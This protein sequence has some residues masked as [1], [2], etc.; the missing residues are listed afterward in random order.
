MKF[1]HRRTFDN[2]QFINKC[3]LVIYIFTCSILAACSTQ[4]SQ[5]TP[6]LINVFVS[7]A[8]YPWVNGFYDCSSPS[9]VINLS[10]PLSADIIVRLG[11]PEQLTTPAFQIS[12]EEILIIVHP[13]SNVTSLTGE[14]VR[15]LFLGQISNWTEVGG[16]DLPVNVWAFSNDEDMQE[17]FDKIVMNGQPVTSLARLATS[18]DGMLKGVKENPGSIGLL[19]RHLLSGDVKEVYSVGSVPVLA[20]TKSEPLGGVKELID[21]LQKKPYQL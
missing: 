9:T 4:S 7:S 1:L 18:A 10:D 17:I 11:E 19:T 16:A 5:A 8:A 15:S 13:Q 14:Q 6:Q 3:N 2:L 21:C 12:T 20:I